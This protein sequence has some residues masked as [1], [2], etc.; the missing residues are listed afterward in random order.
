MIIVIDNVK[1]GTGLLH[2]NRPVIWKEM[3]DFQYSF[4]LLS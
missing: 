3:Q 1:F 2:S 4:L